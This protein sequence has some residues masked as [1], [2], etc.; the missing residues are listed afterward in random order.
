MELHKEKGLPKVWVR[1]F[2][3]PGRIAA[4]HNMRHPQSSSPPP[5]ARRLPPATCHLHPTPLGSFFQ[6]AGKNRW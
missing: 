1:F 3:S 2:K 4:H 5:A 6:T